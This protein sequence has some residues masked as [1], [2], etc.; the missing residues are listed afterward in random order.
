MDRRATTVWAYGDSRGDRELLAAADHP[1]WVREPLAS[2][3]PSI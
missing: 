1:V 3:A 2:V